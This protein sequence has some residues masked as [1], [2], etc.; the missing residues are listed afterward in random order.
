MGLRGVGDHDLRRYG[1]FNWLAVLAIIGLAAYLRLANL[2]GNPGW[3]TDEG[4]HLNIAL[5]LLEGRVAYLAINRSTLLFAKLPLFEAVLAVLL[6]LF[7]GGIST[8]R[9]L[10]GLLGVIAVIALYTLVRRLSDDPILALLSAL[11]LAIYPGAV[12]YNRFGFSYN[13]IT[14]LLLLAMWGLVEYARRSRRMWLA[15]A[16]LAMGL[17]LISDLMSLALIP[18]L[19]LIVSIHDWRDLRWSLPLLALPFGLYA[20]TM[21]VSDPAAF[22]FDLE[23]TF[24]RMGGSSIPAQL[25]TLVLNL[26]M[27]LTGDA[28][29]CAGLIGLFMLRSKHLRGLSLLLLLFPVIA[30]G[31]TVALYGLTFYYMIPLLPLVALGVAALIRYGVPYTDRIIR[32]GLLTMFGG[33]GVDV[34]TVTWQRVIGVTS[35]FVAGVIVGL[36]LLTSTMM[37]VSSVQHG[38]MTQ[39]DPVLIDGGDARQVAEYINAHIHPGDVV[40]ASPAVAW[41]IDGNVADF[42]MAVSAAGQPTPHLPMNIPPDRYTFDPRYE[43]ARYVVIDNLWRNWAGVHIPGVYEMMA[44]MSNWRLVFRSGE[45]EVYENPRIDR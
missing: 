25:T 27:L 6:R 9:A 23:F 32:D 8:L 19:I 12:L 33:W 21:L 29:F 11:I 17:G 1:F 7:G 39:A 5:N 10:T 38:F 28:W 13:L 15:V 36:P 20:V 2:P 22:L 35:H 3:Y 16:A 24:S 45:I 42:Q 41:L 31:R 37:T 34:H 14:P 40:V 44:D 43:R 26:T 4:T 18:P 30:M